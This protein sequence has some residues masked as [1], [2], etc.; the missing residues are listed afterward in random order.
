[1]KLITNIQP[2]LLS[3]IF[4][5]KTENLKEIKAAVAY[6][7]NYEL[8][9]YC[10]KNEIRLDYYGRFDNTLNLDLQ[11]LKSFLTDDI[12]IH[13]IGGNKFHPKV[14]WCN[15]YGAYIGSANLTLS[16]WKNN[17]ECGLWLTQEELKDNQL[18]EPLKGFFRFIQEESKSLKDISDQ[19]ISKLNKL[20]KQKQTQK[21]L[22]NLKADLIIKEIFGV[23]PGC[24][25]N[26]KK[27]EKIVSVRPASVEE[28]ELLKKIEQKILNI[29]PLIKKH[30]VPSYTSYRI[31]LG[32]TL[33]RF[34][35]NTNKMTLNLPYNKIQSDLRNR[36]D[37][38]NNERRTPHELPTRGRRN[39]GKYLES[40]FI[41]LIKKT[42]ST[43]FKDIQLFQRSN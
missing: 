20:K 11:K 43:L 38:K 36:Y 19:D 3:N 18:V 6:C 24:S 21:S 34:Y 1:M 5:E 2:P 30:E 15:N 4:F 16:A 8:F 35:K 33:I 31:S 22:S 39:N 17:I 7:E 14:I 42:F 40:D 13:I 41:N 27:E 26:K 23:F 10:K 25:S 32:K 9:E 37:L 12:S 28:K 29:D